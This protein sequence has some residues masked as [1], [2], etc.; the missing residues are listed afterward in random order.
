MKKQNVP[1]EE[2]YDIGY[3]EYFYSVDICFIEWPEL[4]MDLLPERYVELSIE[5]IDNNQR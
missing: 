3:E 5:E 2:V 4:I 1:I